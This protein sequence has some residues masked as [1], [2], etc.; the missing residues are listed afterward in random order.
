MCVAFDAT[1][2]LGARTGIAAFVAGAFGALAREP[3]VLVGY[4]TLFVLPPTR[5]AAE[6]VTVH[7]LAP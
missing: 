2:I 1:P 3:D 6:V 5:R 7:D 4:G